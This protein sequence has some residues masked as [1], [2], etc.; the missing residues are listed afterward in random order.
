MP[1]N[2]FHYFNYH[3]ISMVCL[4]NDLDS[5]E[6]EYINIVEYYYNINRGVL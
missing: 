3:D 6:K 2:N 4:V 1:Y 5:Y